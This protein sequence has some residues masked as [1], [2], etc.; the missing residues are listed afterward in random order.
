MA[1]LNLSRRPP[2]DCPAPRGRCHPKVAA[3]GC[4]PRRG[5]DACRGRTVLRL[6]GNTGEYPCQD[7]GARS[8]ATNGPAPCREPNNLIGV[9]HRGRR[10][11]RCKA[12]R[13]SADRGI[14][15]P[16]WCVTTVA[17]SRVSALRGGRRDRHLMEQ[18]VRCRCPAVYRHDRG[19]RQPRRAAHDPVPAFLSGRLDGR[20]TEC[21]ATGVRGPRTGPD[22]HTRAARSGS[23]P[24]A[25]GRP[26]WRCAPVDLSRIWRQRGRQR[27]TAMPHRKLDP[28]PALQAPGAN[29]PS[30]G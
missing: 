24:D 10:V 16:T 14:R 28:T 27:S 21:T 5:R 17:P 6:S 3:K 15:T 7:G 22:M 9:P 4:P 19:P 13:V 1:H 2:S 23:L 29:P 18:A 20:P 25:T 12:G 30:D 26:W 8:V 11:P